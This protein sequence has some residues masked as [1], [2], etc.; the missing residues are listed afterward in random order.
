[1]QGHWRSSVIGVETT[2]CEASPSL[3]PK[4]L[5]CIEQV[6]PGVDIHGFPDR[7]MNLC[8]KRLEGVVR[9]VSDKAVSKFS[10][11][12]RHHVERHQET[13]AF[14][15]GKLNWVLRGMRTVQRLNCEPSFFAFAYSPTNGVDGNGP[16]SQIRDAY[17]DMLLERTSITDNNLH[18]TNLNIEAHVLDAFSQIQ[19]SNYGGNGSDA[20]SPCP[21]CHPDLNFLI[22][23]HWSPFVKRYLSPSLAGWPISKLLGEPSHLN[24]PPQSGA[25]SS[26]RSYRP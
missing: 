26:A 13:R 23:R 4:F 14:A 18:Q 21:D 20:G 24:L 7:C 3:L 9:K 12:V 17:A 25:P 19:C 10:F 16:L 22:G 15:V 5:Q 8:N 11:P 1:V 6:F 2:L